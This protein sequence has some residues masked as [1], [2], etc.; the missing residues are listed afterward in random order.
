[1]ISLYNLDNGLILYYCNEPMACMT[2][3][4]DL[5][6]HYIGFRLCV[7]YGQ[8]DIHVLGESY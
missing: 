6:L 1:M 2:R 5:V 7:L 8:L 3:T 4:M